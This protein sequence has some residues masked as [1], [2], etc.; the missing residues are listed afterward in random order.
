MLKDRG[1]IKW[2]SLMLP[3]HVQMLKE[4]WAEDDYQVRPVL[5]DQLLDEI[6]RQMNYAVQKNKNV[7]LMVHLNGQQ[8]MFVGKIQ[9]RLNEQ[10]IILQLSDGR[11]KKIN[12]D[13]IV[14]F[15]TDFDL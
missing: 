6:N 10:S 14:D 5:D 2:T 11:K 8:Q 15:F 7:R 9:Q 4:L 13:T 1:T 12:I 3:E